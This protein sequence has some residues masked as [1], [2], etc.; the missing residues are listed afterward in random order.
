[1]G[2]RKF[3]WVLV[4]ECFDVSHEEEVVCV[5]HGGGDGGEGV[6]VAKFDLRDGEGV[7]LVHNGND[8]EGECFG[9][10]VLRVEILRSFCYIVSGEKDLGNRLVHVGEK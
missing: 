3:P 10:C 5:D 2:V 6:V 9:K 8:T 4:V 1:M 7:I